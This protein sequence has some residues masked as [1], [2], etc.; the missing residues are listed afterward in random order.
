MRAALFDRQGLKDFIVHAVKAAVRHDQHNIAAARVARDIKGNIH[1]ASDRQRAIIAITSIY[2]LH[3]AC[4]RE[5]LFLRH[6]LRLIDT[7][8]D[9]FVRQ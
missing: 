2:I 1:S 5:P 6:F 9:H 3:D 4:N 8:D 7:G